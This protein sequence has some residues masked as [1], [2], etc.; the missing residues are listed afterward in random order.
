[1]QMQMQIIQTGQMA[2]VL[3]KFTRSA[4]INVSCCKYG[5]CIIGKQVLKKRFAEVRSIHPSLEVIIWL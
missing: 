3:G 5:P 2:V 4:I 1:M